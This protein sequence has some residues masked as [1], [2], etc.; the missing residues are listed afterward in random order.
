VSQGG[1]AGAGN[2][3]L[4]WKP[5]VGVGSLWTNPGGS[6]NSL[7]IH[8]AHRN[9]QL[10]NTFN[11]ELKSRVISVLVDLSSAILRQACSTVVWSRPP[12]ASAMSGS[13][14]CV[15]SFASAMATWRGR[16]TLRLR[17]L[18]YISA[19]LIL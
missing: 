6:R 17:F 10:L 7:F 9:D 19:T 18:E 12:K 3:T 15:S 5:V 4:W 1:S 13:E 11:S 14:S 16:A 8:K 2:E